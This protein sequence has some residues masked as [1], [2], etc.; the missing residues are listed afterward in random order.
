M[1]VKEVIK[2]TQKEAADL[3]LYM[4]GIARLQKRLGLSHI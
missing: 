4:D 3:K 2:K 1:D